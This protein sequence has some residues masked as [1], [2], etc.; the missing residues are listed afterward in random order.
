MKNGFTLIEILIALFVLMLGVMGI[1]ALFP[2]NIKSEA[3]ASDKIGASILADSVFNAIKVAMEDAPAL[4]PAL[5][6]PIVITIAHDGLPEGVYELALPIDTETGKFSV[7]PAGPFPEGTKGAKGTDPSKTVF[8]LATE[9]EGYIRNLTDKD[10]SKFAI[11]NYDYTD[12]YSRLSFTIAVRR[13]DPEE[14]N[15]GGGLSDI[16]VRVPQYEF[17]VSI[18][19]DYD[20]ENNNK[21]NPEIE[22]HPNLIDEFTSV[23]TGK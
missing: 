16:Q 11:K 18:Y 23:V 19:K 10:K 7:Y 9:E 5:P 22:R 2:V 14:K 15:Q 3:K 6:K 8:L 20:S 21:Y 4:D 12:P 1:L 17:K 13:I